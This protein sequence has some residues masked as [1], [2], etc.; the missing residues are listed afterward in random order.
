MAEIKNTFTQGKM[1]KDLDERI[2]PNSQYRDAMNVEVTTSEGSN[3][4]TVQNILGNDTIEQFIPSAGYKCV[5][6][7][8][9]EK[10]NSLY[11][12]VKGNNI[13]A[14]L[15]YSVEEGLNS[16]IIDTKAGTSEAVLKFPNKIITGINII[17]DLLLWTDG[18]NEP[19]RINI[20]RCKEG[21]S[22]SA[23]LTSST[24]T[25]LIVNGEDKGD[26]KEDHITAIKKSPLKPL[27]YTIEPASKDAKKPLFEKIFPRFSYRYKFVDGEYSTFAPFT[28]VIFKSLYGEDPSGVD[29]Y[30]KNNAYGI[31]DPYNNGMRNMID[32]INLYNFVAP[33]IPEDVVEIDL[34]YKQD[35][36]TVIY[37]LENIKNTSGNWD[38]DGSN[39]DSNYK[40]NFVVKTEN[41]YAAVP[42]NQSLRIWDNLPKSAIAQEVTGNRVVY[43]NYKQGYNLLDSS[44]NVI[45]PGTRVD[46]GERYLTEGIYDFETGGIPSL[47]SQRDY[48]VGV[49]YGDKYGR[50]TPVFTNEDSS[51]KVDWSQASLANQIQANTT[52]S[53]PE[54]ADYYKFFVKQTSG[55]YYNLIMDA[56]YSPTIEDID[57]DNEKHVWLSFPSSDRNKVSA[58]D[59]IILKRSLKESTQ[60]NVENKYKVLD[61]QNEAPDSIKYKYLTYGEV[62]TDEDV[63]LNTLFLK[64]NKRPSDGN[65][66]LWVD[67]SLWVNDIQGQGMSLTTKEHE[68]SVKDGDLYIS[69]TKKDG[70]DLFMTKRY[71]ISSVRL[72]GG[73]VYLIKLEKKIEKE[74]ADLIVD[75]NSVFKSDTAVIVEK[76]ILKNLEAFSGRFF[77]KITKRGEIEE[78]Q[79]KTEVEVINRISGS[80]SIYWHADVIN[81]VNDH[82]PNTG[83]INSESLHDPL[84][85]ADSAKTVAGISNNITNTEAGWANILDAVKNQSKFFI[86]NMYFAAS[87]PNMSDDQA[88]ARYSGH[89]WK[90][91]RPN[92]LNDV[93]YPTHTGKLLGANLAEF[94][95]SLGSG[96]VKQGYGSSN[97]DK[98][99]IGH[100]N[101]NIIK[102]AHPGAN[103]ENMINGMDGIVLT[104][105]NHTSTGNDAI[106]KW[107]KDRVGKNSF[108]T[109]ADYGTTNGKQILHLSF[110][111]PGDDLHDGNFSV[112]A[113]NLD[114]HGDYG[115][116]KTLQGIWGGGVFTNENGSNIKGE[117]SILCEQVKNGLVT[118]TNNPGTTIGP[119]GKDGYNQATKHK[120]NH[121]RQWKPEWSGGSLN[122]NVK[123]IV[124]RI[125]NPGTKFRF[126]NDADETGPI[127][128]IERVTVKRLYNHTPWRKMWKWDGVAGS[129]NVVSTGHSVEDAAIT[130]GNSSGSAATN[131]ANALYAKIVDFGKRNNRRVCYIITLTD[132]SPDLTA[133]PDFNPVNGDGTA[134][135]DLNS[136]DFE[137]IQFIDPDFNLLTGDISENPAIWETEP[138]E[139]VDLDIYYEA[140]QAFPTKL[141]LENVELFAP[142]GSLIQFPDNSDITSGI[143]ENIFLTNWDLLDFGNG[144]KLGFEISIDVNAI[145]NYVDGV[146][147]G[148]SGVSVRFIRPDGSY[149]T[150]KIFSTINNKIG[151]NRF[152][153]DTTVDPSSEMGLS[154]YNCFSFGNGIESNRIRDDF[155]AMKLSNGVIANS[156]IDRKYKEEHKKNGLIYSGLYSSTGLVNNLNEFISAEKITKDLNPTYGSIQKLFSRR[157]SLIAF[158]EDRVVGITAN[159]NALY[160]ADGNPQLVA[161]NAVLGDA[162]PFVGDYGISKNPE[163]FASESYRAYFTDKQRGA[164]LRLSM[165]GLTPI[166]D[167]GMRDYFRDNLDIPSE[168]IG[169]YDAYKK[170]YNLTL[171]NYLPENVIQNNLIET[172]EGGSIGALI[173]TEF[174]ENNSFTNGTTIS[175]PAAPTNIAENSSLRSVTQIY[176][177]DEILSGTLRSPHPEVVAHNRS[178]GSPDATNRIIFEFI[179]SGTNS[180]Y[181]STI[182]GDPNWYGTFTPEVNP[183][184]IA[185]G[186]TGDRRSQAKL[187]A[188]ASNLPE[189]P[190][191]DQPKF[192]INNSGAPYLKNSI[193]DGSTNGTIDGIWFRTQDLNQ[194]LVDP[195]V[196][197]ATNPAL[198]ITSN[199]TTFVSEEYKFSM[200]LQNYDSDGNDAVDI[201]LQV[202]AQHDGIAHPAFLVAGNSATVGTINT[203]TDDPTYSNTINM[204]WITDNTILLPSFPEG[205]RRVEFYLKA[206]NPVE[207]THI[208]TTTDPSNQVVLAPI[209]DY[210]NVHISHD[211][212]TINN[213]VLIKEFKIEKINKLTHPGAYYIPEITPVPDGDVPAWS[214]VRQDELV[215]ISTSNAGWSATATGTATFVLDQG[216]IDEFGVE[217]HPP[218]SN[219][220]DI[221]N[222]VTGNVTGTESYFSG[223][224]NGV[225]DYHT[226]GFAT[227]NTPVTGGVDVTIDILDSNGNII[228][229][230]GGF[231]REENVISITGANGAAGGV[232]LVQ[233]LTNNT[234]LA[235]SQLE[236]DDWYEV[237]LRGVTGVDSSTSILIQNALDSST[238]PNTL[239]ADPRG[240][241]L[242]GHI[243]V[244]AGPLA[245][246]QQV[247]LVDEGLDP[248]F[249]NGNLLRCIWQQKQNSNLDELKINVFR[250]T[251]AIDAIELTDVTE[252]QTGGD[253]DNW[254][255]RNAPR[256]HT[257]S[258]RN[259]VYYEGGGNIR[260]GY[261]SDPSGFYDEPGYGNGNPLSDIIDDNGNYQSHYAYQT[262]DLDPTNDGYVLTF[263]ISLLPTGETVDAN[264]NVVPVYNSGTL[265]GYITGGFE[266]VDPGWTYGIKFTVEQGGYYRIEGK[267]DGVTQP[268]I[269][270]VDSDY[271]T[272]LSSTGAETVDIKTFAGSG[273]ADKLLFT[274][275]AGG[276]FLGNLKVCSVKDVTN[277]FTPTVAD[278][279]IFDGFDP[280]F[281]NFI[282]FD[283]TNQ[284]IL[285]INA[286]DTVSLQQVTSTNFPTGSVVQL[287]F[288]IQN[289]SSGSISGYY[290]NQN[291]EGFTFGPMSGNTNFD[292]EFDSVNRLT[293][294]DSIAT[295]GEILGA[296]VILVESGP[297]NATL[298]NFE[299]YR[300]YPE[301]TP[302]TISYSEDVKGWVSFKSFIPEAS[303]NISSRYYTFKDAKPYEHYLEGVDYNT[304]YGEHVESSITTILNQQPDTI[305]LFNTLNY[306]GTQSKINQ[307]IIDTDTGLT[308]ASIYNL[309]PDKP[310]WY[311][312]RIVTDKQSGSVK[313]FIEKEGKWFNYIKGA[314]TLDTQLP[315]TAEFSFQGLGNVSITETISGSNGGNGS[316]G[317]N[318]SNGT[319]GSNGA[320]GGTGGGTGGGNGY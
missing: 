203:P 226:Q 215:D 11:W 174:I 159:K 140:S 298:D 88:Y 52:T 111:A 4:G 27:S 177:Y 263:Q 24:H 198:P 96:M 9:N 166:S 110:L 241:T 70:D 74:D 245:D 183:S 62:D 273:H 18:T 252:K 100:P 48:Q 202:F 222:P 297:F 303:A 239:P 221:I 251:G 205:S 262:I 15:E 47:K 112:T 144:P 130:W 204:G 145:S 220:Y 197:A 124:D 207:G 79:D 276:E 235:N 77:V 37:V 315:S 49:V 42:D 26:I 21:S 60:I 68:T 39:A 57:P 160:N 149:T 282:N 127:Y 287:K 305:K 299:L 186:E 173:A 206:G 269:T 56:V 233:D 167:A 94:I 164:V 243:G 296:L 290:Y 242:P 147:V 89:G 161:S 313:E 53:H 72:S 253:V 295:G 45:N 214:A 309:G 248:D 212:A 67:K 43:A 254:S 234:N 274:P 224:S 35:N 90:G 311:A 292:S 58:E 64:V 261:K 6:S 32:E 310:G 219:S 138:K 267:L 129:A 179:Q 259:R 81:S 87:Q 38:G 229:K 249:P 264:G 55:E 51:F 196:L 150:G 227:T 5:G 132:D 12:F 184:L 266:D 148:F 84:T 98:H 250:F 82:D 44:S 176:N 230:Q 240:E 63:D 135:L 317:A 304:F 246:P 200:Y 13:D 170:D 122:Q 106:K 256:Y 268:T 155:N 288:D 2:L 232:Q 211:D 83:I 66:Y 279:W 300:I 59:Y 165:D 209:Y 156:T 108:Y 73:N 151:L 101:I 201:R 280:V 163:S 175:N 188:A 78:L 302:T 7:I 217:N 316:N 131:N 225:T 265:S 153:I 314:E 228:G 133:D 86:D 14:V 247:R 117:Q 308:N 162:N 319:N 157:V 3:V 107:R 146:D 152:R 137:T 114:A 125:T 284:N 91:G 185:Y 306:E 208:D 128:T 95:P 271:I 61:V 126:K 139:N 182:N 33:D 180:N 40:G 23:S 16:V 190:N 69:W 283:D 93:R 285:F 169:S 275:I 210:L 123:K 28:D 301:F 178:Y 54:W 97:Y 195:D 41:I 99:S 31:E 277:Y 115:L 29:F 293:V 258:P 193:N 237:K 255:L 318:G 181:S 116:A 286:P 289:Y 218:T 104:S 34:L 270:R 85:G 320:N 105:N 141:T 102:P 257:Y 22:T 260:W 20:N 143:N 71:K 278:S 199:T 46:Y 216:A 223:T 120:H 281:D 30:D 113:N 154:W 92:A 194:S 168:L 231:G 136:V 76:K 134:G 238:F 189:T 312:D 307:F 8:S 192:T 65:S 103:G 191:P 17:D 171:S 1:N 158:C 213:S 291:G 36:S 142:I 294:G 244:I 50:E 118:K 80:K 10:T 187:E 109:A 121:L 25:K 172:G 272:P 75:S 236:I 19:R 119:H